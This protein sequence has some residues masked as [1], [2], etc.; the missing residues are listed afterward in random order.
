MKQT[1]ART[2][3]AN[4]YRRWRAHEGWPRRSARARRSLSSD[5]QFTPLRP[6]ILR[7][8]STDILRVLR[9][10][11]LDGSG[12]LDDGA[13]MLQ[14]RRKSAQPLPSLS[15]G[16]V[17]LGQW[18]GCEDLAPWSGDRGARYIWPRYGQR[19]AGAPCTEAVGGFTGASW[20]R[21]VRSPWRG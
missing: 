20:Q 13:C 3:R 1:T 6:Q 10:S 18:C 4:T 14:P 8:E 16:F 17:L 11:S 2:W 12:Q 5:G 21:R 15:L 19:W 9:R 7:G